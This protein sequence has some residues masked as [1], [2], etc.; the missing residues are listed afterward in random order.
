MTRRSTSGWLC[1]FASDR[2]DSGKKYADTIN[3]FRKTLGVLL[4]DAADAITNG[5]T[6]RL[7]VH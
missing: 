5:N 2:Q 4:L 6:R 1:K 7:V 3:R